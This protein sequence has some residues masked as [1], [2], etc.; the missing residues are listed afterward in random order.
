ME[1]M[2]RKNRRIVH[3]RTVLVGQE[4]V[5]CTAQDYSTHSPTTK[6]VGSRSQMIL[7]PGSLSAKEM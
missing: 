2:G 6:S 5:W 1:D 3:G 4:M 7:L